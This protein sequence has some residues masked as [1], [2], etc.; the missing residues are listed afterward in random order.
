MKQTVVLFFLIF[1]LYSSVKAQSCNYLQWSDEFNYS[2]APDPNKW[3]YDLGDHGWGNNELQDY[4]NSRVNSYVEDGKLFIKAI[5]QNDKWTSA[6]LVTRQKGDWLYGR[7]EVSAKLPTGK[8]TWPAIWMLPTDWNYGGWPASGEIDIMEHVGYDQNKIYGSI[9]TEA[10]NHKIGTQKSGTRI[11]PSASTGFNLYAIEWSES[12]IDF[13]INNEKYFTFANENKTYKEWPFDK[14]FHLLL[15][16]AIGGNW[17]GAQGIDPSLTQAIMEVDYVKVFTKKPVKPVIEGTSLVV[18]GAEATFTCPKNNDFT[19]RWII[20]EGAIVISG[21]NTNEL[22]IQWGEVSGYIQVELISP[23]D[24]L[25]SEPFWVTATTNPGIY[26]ITNRISEVNGWNGVASDKNTIKL[27][28]PA[29]HL[30]Q[31]D[32]DIQNPSLNPLVEYV[33]PQPANFLAMPAMKLEMMAEAGKGPSNVRVDLLDQNGISNPEPLFKIDNPIV[34]GQFQS[35]N[36]VF[37][38]QTTSFNMAAIKK[39]RLYF[40]YGF[41]GKKGS[42]AFQLN[43][44]IMNKGL[45]KTMQTAGTVQCFPNPVNDKLMLM[46]LGSSEIEMVRL[47]DVAGKTAAQ[48]KIHSH[49]AAIPF[50]Q[51]NK[52]IYILEVKQGA[53]SSRIKVVKN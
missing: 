37:S 15:N 30:L 52:G 53:Y 25:L 23:C 22:K 11:I 19:Y 48:F 13:F 21:K 34:N 4:T 18:A 9:H 47:F 46:A 2:G 44:L 31:V 45:G 6:R 33:F 28:Q 39:I 10:F 17:G 24:T 7:I 8:G 26:P 14:R 20:P 40:N 27:S 42:G 1:A 41:F 38:A 36:H 35:Y 32:F 12:K 29:P 3:G 43:E 51:F 49:E 50:S 5:K 16:L